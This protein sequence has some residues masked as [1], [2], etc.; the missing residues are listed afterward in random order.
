M[1]EQQSQPAM[2]LVL[3][4]NDGRQNAVIAGKVERRKGHVLNALV[5]AHVVI[6][7][8]NDGKGQLGEQDKILG[9]DIAFSALFFLTTSFV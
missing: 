7:R 6:P 1:A 2:Q 3:W 9:I 4:C 8:P 5:I